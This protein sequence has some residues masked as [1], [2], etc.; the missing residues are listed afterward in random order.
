MREYVNI[1]R[2][3]WF[4]LI[5]RAMIRDMRDDVA[6][7]DFRRDRVYARLDTNGEMRFTQHTVFDQ[8]NAAPARPPDSL[9]T[10]SNI[11]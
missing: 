8:N 3:A 10:L 2:D 9:S 6:K 4:L 11:D 1:T 5:T 7:F